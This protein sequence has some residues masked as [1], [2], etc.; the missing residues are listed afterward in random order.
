MEAKRGKQGISRERLRLRGRQRSFS[1][2]FRKIGQEHILTLP[3]FL[4]Q[5]L[6]YPHAAFPLLTRLQPLPY[7][8]AEGG[9]D[10]VGVGRARC[11]SVGTTF[12]KPF[13]TSSTNRTRRQRVVGSYAFSTFG[14]LERKR[15]RG[16]KRELHRL[17]LRTAMK[18]VR[19][20]G[21]C[22]R[23]HFIM[24]YLYHSRF[25]LSL[26]STTTSLSLR[27]S[28]SSGRGGSGA[29]KRLYVLFALNPT[30]NRLGLSRPGPA[31]TLHY[32]LLYCFAFR[33]RHGEQ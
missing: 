2:T 32:I 3:H 24:A 17:L 22:K 33:E 27:S 11:S 4:H 20:R 26:P 31:L 25:A 14:L 6:F 29:G 23:I 28:C 9:A 10:W 8:G 16:K 18:T 13:L 12:P 1:L 19:P 15:M 30:P 21:C 7:F 5:P